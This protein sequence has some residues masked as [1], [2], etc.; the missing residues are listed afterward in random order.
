MVGEPRDALRRA[1]Y[2]SAIL[3]LIGNILWLLISGLAMAVGYLIAGVLLCITII[4]IPFG[5]AAFRMASY[6]LWPFGR[7]AVRD[8]DRLPAVSMIG[9][10]L[11]FLLAGWWLALG[12]LVTGAI[13]CLT[14]IG[15]PF[16]IVSFGLTK[17][18]LAPLGRRVVPIGDAS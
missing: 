2:A 13:L 1:A 4:G 5:I 3:R 15:I 17:I 16:G 11:W 14:I 9:N 8:P 10:I 7:T 12:H 18:A 6:A